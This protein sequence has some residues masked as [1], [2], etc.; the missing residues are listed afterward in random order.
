MSDYS[1]RIARLQETMRQQGAEL[2]VFAPTDNMR[3]LTGWAEYG[4]ERLI[5]LLVPAQGE[6]AFVV[7]AMNTQQAQSNPAG[8]RCVLGWN[9]AEGWQGVAEALLRQWNIGD[10]PGALALIDDEL[11]SVH[12]LDLQALFPG[13][14]YVAAGETMARLRE[15]KTPAELAAM[16][17]AA[18]LIDAIYEESL[19]A[20]TEGMIELDLKDF[21]LAAFK[22]HGTQASFPP[23]ICFGA[24]G[25]MPHHHTGRTPLQ[26]G[27]TVVIDVGCMWEGYASDITRTVAFGEP[28]DP[29]AASVY[30]IV[31]RAHWAAREATRPGAS[32]EAVDAAARQV[33]TEAGYGPQFIHRTG[34]G[35]G[36][37][38]HEPPYIVAGN[39]APLL[40]GMCFSIEPGIYL[41]GRFGVRI[42]NIV[43]MTPDGARSLN[44]EAPR[45]LPVIY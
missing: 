5:A 15:I 23:L 1:G 6:P 34:H 22:R 39:T 38:T 35:I 41:P 32:G 31:S 30:E 11:Y 17:T 20:L 16:E 36:L 3:Y 9:D 14:R 42:E 43:T 2:A 27:D 25:A 45:K 37:S 19:A 33:I 18:R 28:R 8:L 44:A 21:F 7:P 24:N 29:E 4:H 13:L 10:K 26:R 40:P 12:L